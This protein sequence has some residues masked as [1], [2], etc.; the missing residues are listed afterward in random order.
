MLGLWRKSM[1]IEYRH[2]LVINDASWQPQA[3]TVSRVEAVLHNWV[4]AKAIKEIVDLS[5]GAKNR[6][7][8]VANITSPG[9]G[10]AVV[11]SGV[12]GSSVERIAGPS[13]YENIDPGE[14]YIMNT[15]IVVGEDIR[16]QWSS[17]SIYF[18][19]VSPPNANDVPIFNDPNEEP[20]DTLFSQSF[21]SK[22]IT[23]LPVVAAHIENHAKLSVAWN[24]CLGFW[25]GA[26]VINF[27]KDLPSFTNYVHAL[28]ARD[29]VA[30]I[31]AAFRGPIIEI[32]EFYWICLRCCIWR[33]A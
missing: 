29:F 15:T 30:E 7:L 26:L 11:Y 5:L 10:I 19:L 18:E 24:E 23:A 2:F 20:Y 22:N 9:P 33:C 12:D 16:I 32:G 13:G 14:R 17:E 1:G 27:G 31:S 21:S 6:L 4:I 3:D 25:R 8:N 28:P